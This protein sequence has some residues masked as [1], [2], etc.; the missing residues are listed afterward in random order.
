MKRNNI[1]K[2]TTNNSSNE[3]EQKEILQDNFLDLCIRVHNLSKDNALLI[4]RLI[5]DLAENNKVYEDG[6]LPND[7]DFIETLEQIDSLLD[8]MEASFDSP[9]H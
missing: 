7:G 3:I 5:F 6:Y 8:D 2:M 4:A 1:T 9:I